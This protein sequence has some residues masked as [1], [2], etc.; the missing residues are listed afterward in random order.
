V[1]TTETTASN[2]GTIAETSDRTRIYQQTSIDT[3]SK[4]AFAKFYESR[5]PITAAVE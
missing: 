3:Y 5:T 2:I 4:M 1:N